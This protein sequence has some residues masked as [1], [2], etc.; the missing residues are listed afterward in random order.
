MSIEQLSV[1]I[2]DDSIFARKNLINFISSLG[3]ANIFEAADGE[4]SVIKYKENKPD[5]VF[6]DII[7]PK[8]SGIDAVTEI[9]TF[10]STAKVVMVSSVGTQNHLKD[11]IKAGAYD[12]LQKPIEQSHVLRI[13]QKIVRED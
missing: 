10:D 6:M 13:L 4:E 8:K 12:F 11:A 5:L 9:L 2:C 7:M 3:V 1:L